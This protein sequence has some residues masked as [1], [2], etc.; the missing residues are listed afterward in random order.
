MPSLKRKEDK[1]EVTIKEATLTDEEEVS[2][3]Y[4]RYS[5]DIINGDSK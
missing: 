1:K 3:S 2:E 4:D 5:R